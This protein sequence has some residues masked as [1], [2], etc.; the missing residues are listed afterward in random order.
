MN[1]GG[2]TFCKVVVMGLC[3]TVCSLIISF[4]F[5]WELGRTEL[6]PEL[7][8]NFFHYIG[9]IMTVSV[10]HFRLVFLIARNWSRRTVF[11]KI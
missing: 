5:L 11:Q 6:S 1:N 10:Q 4:I 3:R 9:V 7:S 2:K 8:E